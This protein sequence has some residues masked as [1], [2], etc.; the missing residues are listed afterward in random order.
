MNWLSSFPLTVAKAMNDYKGPS[1]RYAFAAFTQQEYSDAY[2][3]ARAARISCKHLKAKEGI[4]A[5]QQIIHEE[6]EKIYWDK[7]RAVIPHL[8]EDLAMNMYEKG[9]GTTCIRKY[10]I[11][12]AQKED[13]YVAFWGPKAE[14]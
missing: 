8:A 1:Q 12:V 9:W 13:N 6:L 4:P 14:F 10:V 7:R 2:K 3:V 11:G 5:V